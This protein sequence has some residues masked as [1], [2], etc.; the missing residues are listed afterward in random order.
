ME[1]SL[2]TFSS[3]IA[4]YFELKLVCGETPYE[5]RIPEA[6]HHAVFAM[7][8]TFSKDNV[9]ELYSP[10]HF[11]YIVVDEFHHSQAYTYKKIIRH[12]TPQFLLGLTA[13]PERMD[14]RDILELCDNTVERH[15]LR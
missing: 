9:L 11:D 12:F 10:E 7:V 13:T 1:K 8:Q 3:V 15:T 4:S 2:E 14:G 6:G 5:D